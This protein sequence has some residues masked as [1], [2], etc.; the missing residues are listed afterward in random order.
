M[1]SLVSG[2]DDAGADASVPACPGWSVRDVVAHL[3][4]IAQDVVAGRLSRLPSDEE[5]AAQVA[6]FT[7]RDI[8]HALAAWT[9]VA[10]R[11]ERVI[12]TFRLHAPL[13]DI[14]S[15]E[16]DI[17]GALGE[18]GARSTEAVWYCAERLLTGLRTPVPLRVVVEDAEFRVGPDDEAELLLN[19]GRFECLRWRTGR[20][21]RAQ[22]RALDWSGDPTPL[23]DHLVLFGPATSDVVE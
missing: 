10:P 11:F 12:D 20:R 1:I 2:L 4:A 14:T 8:A 18:R 13:I 5:T 16:H 22:L 23:L 7:G 3:A 9:D 15:H 17:R 6:R 19:T 21:S